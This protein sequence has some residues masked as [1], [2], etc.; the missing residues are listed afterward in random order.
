MTMAMLY[1]MI[2]T[3]IAVGGTVAYGIFVSLNISGLLTN[4]VICISCSSYPIGCPSRQYI[5]LMP[6]GILAT[7]LRGEPFPPSR[8]HLG[9]R[10]IIVNVIA[11]AF[12]IV[13]WIFQFIPSEPSPSPVDMNVEQC[14][15]GVRGYI[16]LCLLCYLGKA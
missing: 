4:Y 7:R 5:V 8:F 2:L 15:L 11:L 14:D 9:K 16:L 12:L 3:L 10:G 1:T 13:F 6:V